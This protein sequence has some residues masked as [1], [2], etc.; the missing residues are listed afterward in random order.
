VADGARGRREAIQQL[1]D[2]RRRLAA[3]EDALTDALAAMKQAEWAFDAASDRSMRP[4][5]PSMRPANS[6]PPR[7]GTGMRPGRHTSV[8]ARPR[9]GW[10]GACV[11]SP[12]GWTARPG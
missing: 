1:A 5:V 3:A 6:A 2:L 7:G 4:S 10:S 8:P 11:T 9:T 12:S